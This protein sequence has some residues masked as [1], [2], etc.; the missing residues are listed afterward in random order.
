MATDNLRPRIESVLD[1]YA[2]KE[3]ATGTTTIEAATPPGAEITLN[4]D[5]TATVALPEEAA[6]LE[7]EHFAN[8]A[9]EIDEQ[10]LSVIATDLID[11]IT[12]DK[13]A[14]KKR[15]EQYEEGI[16]RT[17]LGDDA[18]GG[19]AF[20][21]ASRV[22]HP[23]LTEACIDFAARVMGEMLPPSGPVK[24]FII[25]TNDD[26]KSG[27]AKRTARYMNLQ[28]TELMPSAY[29]EF[30]M[31]F[32]QCPLGGAFYTKMYLDDGHPSIMYVPIDK[33]HRPW[34]D[35]D[36]YSQNR[37]THEQD[38]DRWQCLDNVRRKL[39]RDVIDSKTSTEQPDET[40]A[41]KANDRVI[42]RD[43]PDQNIDDI[44]V[45][46]EISVMLP[47]E[48]DDS[49]VLP[50]L[51][52][53]DVNSKKVLA[54]YRNWQESDANRKRLD[55]LIEW[56][57]WPW[58][59]GY[60]IGM[61]HMIGGLAGAATGAL[62][63]LLD[64]AFMNNSQ[65]GIKLKGGATVGGQNIR[66]Q[67]AQ[68]TEVQGSL[69]MDDIRK[70]YMQLPFN[71]PSPVLFQ[72]LGFLVD[73]AKGVVRTTFDEYDKFGGQTPV[74]T[75]QMFVEQGLKNLGAIH[76]RL[77]RSMRRVLRQ[78]W[79]INARIVDNEE[80]IDSFG[81]L[82]VT[83]EDFR[84]PMMVIPV[85][86]PRIFSDMQR[87][88][89]GQLVVQRASA[90]AAAGQ[91]GQPPLYN[92]RK[93][94]LYFLR[95][96]NV[97][98]PE[99]FLTE[100]HEAVQTNAVAEN[101]TAAQG[102]PVDVY[103]GQDHEAHLATHIAF[104]QSPLF[105]SNPIIAMKYLPVIL[106]HLA[107]H[108]AYWY[109]DAS[110][111]AANAAV[112]TKTGDHTLT[113]ESLAAVGGAEVSLDRLLAELSPIVLQHADE[114]LKVLP[115][116]IAQAQ[117]IMQ[118]LAPPQPM[119]PSIVAMKDVDR[120]SQADQASLKLKLVESQGRQQS[121]QVKMQTEQQRMQMEQQREQ[122]RMQLGALKAQ[123]AQ[124]EQKQRDIDSMFKAHELEAK[125]R[126]DEAEAATD[127]ERVAV[128]A[129]ANA[130]KER[131]NTADNQTALEITK[132][133]IDATGKPGN[134]S[135]GTGINP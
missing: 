118:R 124:E 31:G 19:A 34:T 111:E 43:Q 117:M 127:Q 41:S 50:Y 18:P 74:G 20:N 60:P 65:T 17:G 57:F 93:T 88:M 102:Y 110:L 77:H 36:F 129:E 28:M 49:K 21:G 130:V 44:R 103:A 55:F 16:R 8:L 40:R 121:E 48:D 89:L 67:V 69:S 108:I 13:N 75:A 126:A 84:G 113:V 58:R 3:R 26:E 52:T 135:T 131:T 94:E 90:T 119:D 46:Y 114:T 79:D 72:L 59:G 47:L 27:R 37:I 87:S 42:G 54:I 91:P 29:H 71:P 134:L 6:A 105:G 85:S 80:V 35:G 32:T 112:R 68:T 81:E 70:T 39:W 115:Q 61:T 15:D 95:Q 109:A 107:K 24:E 128:A 4:E 98:Q 122:Q 99:Q 86:D 10:R 9:E 38:I 66:P 96:M 25:G 33:V 63:A 51:V 14:R 1:P 45:V 97:P 64:S 56:P 73:S 125:Q 132:E 2:Q 133:K 100:V 23:V 78:L 120:Q 7:E 116:I 104:L 123:E 12:I 62:R 106:P 76:G 101:V 83:K 11:A 82:I 5:G 92:M 30:E 22:V 53:I